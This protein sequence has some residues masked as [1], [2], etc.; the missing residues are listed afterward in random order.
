[1]IK[2]DNEREP[3]LRRVVFVYSGRRERN[4]GNGRKP[5]V[6]QPDVLFYLHLDSQKLNRAEFYIILRLRQQIRIY[7]FAK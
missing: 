4:N 3:F 1:M 5:E 6:L 7:P 2:G